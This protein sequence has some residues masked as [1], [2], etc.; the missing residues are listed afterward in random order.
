MSLPCD[1][2]ARGLTATLAAPAYPQTVEDLQ[3]HTHKLKDGTVVHH[4][5]LRGHQTHG[6]GPMSQDRVVKSSRPYLDRDR[7][8]QNDRLAA[9]TRQWL[10]QQRILA[11]NVVGAPGAGK[12]SLLL[13][14]LRH[15]QQRATMASRGQLPAMGVIEG[16]QETSQDADRIR[17]TGT[18]AV[19]INTGIHSHLDAAMVQQ[20]L[21]Q[22]QPTASS[23]VMIENVGNLVCPALFDLGEAAKVTVLSVTEGDDKPIKYPHLFRASQVM[24]L[25]K[26]DL[27]P[28]LTFDVA[29]CLGYARQ[30]NPHLQV[31]Q[32]STLTGQGLEGWYQWLSS[33]LP[34]DMGRSPHSSEWSPP[35]EGKRSPVAAVA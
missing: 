27:L 34:K 8:T 31:L 1:D 28:H 23:V 32:V 19:Q 20:G 7:L 35:L 21:T 24:V 2:F 33:R 11:L 3:E 13:Q 18:Q 15:F 4:A 9:Q 22:L 30:V 14:T 10:Q 6:H 17:A 16:D 12:T 5:H 26:I 25:N 29:R